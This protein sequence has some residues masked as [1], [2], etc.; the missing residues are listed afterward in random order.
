M[1]FDV[2]FMDLN[3][4]WGSVD[5]VLAFCAVSHIRPNWNALSSTIW[6]RWLKWTAS[7]MKLKFWCSLVFSYLSCRTQIAHKSQKL[8]YRIFFRAHIWA[9]FS[10]MYRKIRCDSYCI[11]I[12]WHVLAS[13]WRW[14]YPM[15]LE[16]VRE[17]S[18][19]LSL[20]EPPKRNKRDQ[21]ILE[22]H[23]VVWI[24]HAL[25]CTFVN[26]VSNPYFCRT[27]K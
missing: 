15:W 12:A 14:S 6:R 10:Y 16:F 5:S 9:R 27:N 4:A 20:F 23:I 22:D 7:W 19:V 21:S 24:P 3:R 18:C 25:V 11:T 1:F 2:K 26:A 8:S 17:S 13:V